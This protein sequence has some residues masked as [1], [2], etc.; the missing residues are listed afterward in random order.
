[1]LPVVLMAEWATWSALM[2]ELRIQCWGH[3]IP[4]LLRILYLSMQFAGVLLVCQP[5]SAGAG[6]GVL[7]GGKWEGGTDQREG[8][9]GGGPAQGG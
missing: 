8:G 9:P 3:L 1:M 7:S 6:W 5:S 2:G 4:H